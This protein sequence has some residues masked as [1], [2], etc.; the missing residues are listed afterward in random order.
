MLLLQRAE[1]SEQRAN[2]IVEVVKAASSEKDDLRETIKRIIAVAYKSLHCDR[3]TLFLCDH[4]KRTLWCVIS[5]DS[6]GFKMPFGK[7]I[8]GHVADTGNELIIRDCYEHELFNPEVDKL[9]KYKTRSMIALPVF[10][11]VHNGRIKFSKSDKE[12]GMYPTHYGQ[13]WKLIGLI[14]FD[15]TPLKCPVCKK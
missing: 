7:G 3:V 14:D 6:E 12:S 8:V 11:D 1:F 13:L 2:A 10:D 4:A 5:K 9:T 15:D